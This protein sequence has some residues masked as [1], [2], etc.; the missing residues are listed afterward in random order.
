[1]I[2][3]KRLTA[4]RLLRLVRFGV[5]GGTGVVVN[6]VVFRILLWALPDSMLIEHQIL[7][8]NF[9]GVIVSIFTNFLLNDRWTWGDREK[10]ENRWLGRLGKYYLTASVAGGVQLGVT[11]L[12]FEWFW[13]HMGLE[14]MGHALSPDLALLTGIASGMA[15]NFVVSH[16]WTF[17][18]A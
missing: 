3:R 5:V 12:S 6:L 4:A 17:K 13:R 16:V 14:L 11:S 7:V 2:M 9:V 15:I 8:A 1:M 18:D 10:G